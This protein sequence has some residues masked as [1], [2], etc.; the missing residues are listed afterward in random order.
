MQYLVSFAS[1]PHMPHWVMIS[2]AVLVLFGAIGILARRPTR[3]PTDDTEV[4]H[5]AEAALF[6][7]LDALREE[8]PPVLAPSRRK[9]EPSAESGRQ[10]ASERHR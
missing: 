5:D 7:E 1:Q 6:R 2:G 8:P 9:Q 4:A 3:G 10:T